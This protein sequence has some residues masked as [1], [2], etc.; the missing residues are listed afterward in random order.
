VVEEAGVGDQEGEGV[1]VGEEVGRGVNV[2][3][4]AGVRVAVRVAVA[5]FHNVM[6]GWTAAGLER[7]LRKL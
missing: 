3:L 2:T 5:E 7:A 1:M 4:G 6:V